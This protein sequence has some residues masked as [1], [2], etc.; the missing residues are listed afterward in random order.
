MFTVL[1]SFGCVS[2]QHSDASS[3]FAMVFS[4]DFN[5]AGQAA[6]GHLQAR[7]THTH[8]H[9]LTHTCVFPSHTAASPPD[10]DVGQMEGVSDHPSRDEFPGL[11]SNA[12]GTQHGDEVILEGGGCPWPWGVSAGDM[13]I[14]IIIIV[15]HGC[16]C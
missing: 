15:F 4:L 8:T 1:R 13:S 16:E 9:T 11:L 5:H 14:I 6:A 12:G 3:R 7:P 2:S 10:D